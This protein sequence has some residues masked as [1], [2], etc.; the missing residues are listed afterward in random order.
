[1]FKDHKVNIA[2]LLGVIPDE[3]LSHLS[4]KTGVD[5]YS[6]VLQGKKL[7]YLLLYG[8]QENDRLS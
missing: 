8:L 3:M 5:Y 1:M 6:K 2:E 4:G 7:F